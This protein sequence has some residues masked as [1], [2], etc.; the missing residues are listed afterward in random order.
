MP[1]VVFSGHIHVDGHWLVHAHIAQLS[2]LEI[3]GDPD[4]IEVD[5]PHQFLAR[6][7][8]LSNFN[9]STGHHT[10][11]GRHDSRVLQVELR[12]IER[13]LLLLDHRL[14]GLCPRALY[15]YLFGTGSG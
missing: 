4:V 2:L 11:Y 15:S 5:D 3:R 10:V 7:H 1:F 9:G 12:L 13:G 14:R 6:L 8:V